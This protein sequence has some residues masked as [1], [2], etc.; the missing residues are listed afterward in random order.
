MTEDQIQDLKAI[1]AE[2]EMQEAELR[3]WM[4]Q[5]DAEQ[6][7]SYRETIGQLKATFNEAVEL[8]KV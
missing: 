8:A 4:R 5:R 2:I 1:A 6:I 7:A 3:Y